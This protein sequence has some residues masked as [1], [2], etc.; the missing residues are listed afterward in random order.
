MSVILLLGAVLLSFLL[1]G[2]KMGVGMILSVFSLMLLLAIVMLIVGIDTQS[3]MSIIGLKGV[4]YYIYAM[5]IMGAIWRVATYKRTWNDFKTK[6]L[7]RKKINLVLN[8][9]RNH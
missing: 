9:Y 8:K 6:V 5:W 7:E 3:E 4:A 1:L 2:W